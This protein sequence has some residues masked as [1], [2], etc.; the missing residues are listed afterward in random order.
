MFFY[1]Q[2]TFSMRLDAYANHDLEIKKYLYSK[3]KELYLNNYDEM[4]SFFLNTIELEKKNVLK[5][6]NKI[7]Y[8]LGSLILAPLR[9]IKSLIKWK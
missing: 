8:K 4:I 1:R 6:K 2:H 3:H 9:F 7:D 5:T